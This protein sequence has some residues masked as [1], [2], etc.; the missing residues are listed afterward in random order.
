MNWFTGG[1][2]GEA[3]RLIVQLSDPYKRDR[4]GQDLIRMGADGIPILIESLAT[5]DANLRDLIAHALVQIGPQTVSPLCQ[6]LA[7]AHPEVRGQAATILGEIGGKQAVPALLE[8]VQG[9]FYTVRA[10]AALALGQIRDAQ[11]IPALTSALQDREPDARAAAARALGQFADPRTF[12]AIGNVLLDDPQIEVRQAAAES[13]GNTR[14][15]EA[16][17]YLVDAL[18]DSFWWYE[19]EQAVNDLLDAIVK[20]G[21]AVVPEL[22]NDLNNSEGT[23]RRFAALLLARLPDQRAVEALSISLYDTHP[24]VCKASAEALAAIGAPA[25]SVLMDALRH[26]EA[27]IRQQAVIGL[28]K[29]RDAQVVPA[30]LDLLRDENRDVCKQA[31]HSL[32]QLRD[33]RALPALQALAASRTD[34]E[35][36]ALAKQALQNFQ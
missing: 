11:A 36:A 5:R 1:R 31:A 34:R 10:K 28:A 8:A 4:A 13:L 14:R 9:E 7:A 6:A 35:M 19:R 16:I 21:N 17:P 22:I 20:M 15:P 30:L 18:H 2:T 32:G 27:W 3:R 25:L 12:E 29:S 33:P 24:D 26:P 23:V